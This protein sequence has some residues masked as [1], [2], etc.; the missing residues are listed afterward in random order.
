MG[1]MP[2]LAIAKIS[3]CSWHGSLIRRFGIQNIN[4]AVKSGSLKY[5]Y[6]N[7]SSTYSGP[8]PYMVRPLIC[9]YMNAN[10]RSADRKVQEH[11]VNRPFRDRDAD[12]QRHLQRG[13]ARP[14]HDGAENDGRQRKRQP[15]TELN[16]KRL[17][18][19]NFSP[20]RLQ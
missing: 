13:A 16:D 5:Q 20:L 4:L 2:D 15:T 19:P 6:L 11:G 1:D 10:G 12:C 7:N 9:P 14:E 17:F 8:T 18:C 3:V